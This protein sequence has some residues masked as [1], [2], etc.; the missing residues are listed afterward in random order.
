MTSWSVVPIGEV[1][2]I[3]SKTINP[4][5]F[6]TEEFALY[7]IPAY[8]AG[9]TPERVRG[10]DI[11]SN[12]IFLPDNGILFSKLNPRINRV[13][14]FCSSSGSKRISSTEFICLAPDKTKV[15]PAYLAW[16]LRSPSIVRELPVGTAAATK[17]RERFPPKALLRVPLL[18]PPLDEQRRIVEVLERAAGIRRRREQALDKARALIPALFLDMFGDPATNPKGWEIRMLGSV[19]EVQGGLQVTKRRSSLP[20]EAPYLRVA[21]VLRDELDLEEVKTIR[22]TDSELSRTRLV[23]GD[24]LVVEG[25]GNANEIGRAAVWDGSIEGC[26]HQNHLIRVRA[27]SDR[28]DSDFAC[29]FLNSSS[30]RRELLRAGKTTSGLNTI[31][32]SNVKAVKLLLPPMTMQAAFAERVADIRGIIARQ[33]RSLDA[34][35]ALER[36]LMARLLG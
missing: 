6:C 29:A 32:T 12:K 11:K 24:I 15:L 9:Q 7:S 21:N 17:S 33:E 36:S 30:G 16:R 14:Q 5:K 3:V 1:A 23:A 27:S 26:V 13:W 18:L 20:H 2:K 22:L 4:K 8:D 28:L 35:R 31:S 25:H 10:K 34:A 19:A